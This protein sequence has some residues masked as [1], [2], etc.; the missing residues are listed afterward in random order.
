AKTELQ[1]LPGGSLPAQAAP[2]STR[3]ANSDCENRSFIPIL[4]AAAIRVHGVAFGGARFVD[5]ALEQAAD[6]CV[7]QG[8]AIVVLGVGQHFVFALGLIQRN[9]G[10]LLEPADFQRAARTLVEQLD[11][12]LVYL[13]DAAAP[14]GEVHG[15]ASQKDRKSTRLNSSHLV[16]SYTVCCFK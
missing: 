14:I 6:R 12:F 9:V 16:T 4:P 7:G 11:Q 10:R 1:R 3:H 15:F 13:V 8:P 2:A 5:D